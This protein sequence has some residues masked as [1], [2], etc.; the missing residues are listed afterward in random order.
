MKDYGMITAMYIFSYLIGS[1][2]FAFIIGKLKGIDLRRF[3]SGN[4]GATNAGRALGKKYFFIVL[5]LDSAKGALAVLIARYLIFNHYS[6][7]EKDTSYLLWILTGFFAIVG[8]N[9]PIWLKFKGGKGVATSLGVVI[10]I[11][12][13]YTIPAAVSFI[14]W[15]VMV[16]ATGYVSVGS[17][18][19]AIAFILTFL[20]CIYAI[21]SWTLEDLWPLLAIGII[22]SLILIYRHK[23]NIKRLLEGKENKFT[24]R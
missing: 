1:V 19:S 22:M 13:Y 23:D 6:L 18:F 11:Y 14:V 16:F 24:L 5:A 2:P 9:W 7:P 20:I 4:V 10:A 3:G 17:M 12:P 15:L 21:P 8:H